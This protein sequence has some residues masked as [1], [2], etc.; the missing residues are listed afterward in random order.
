M[1]ILSS[2]LRDHSSQ[3]HYG[4]AT[5]AWKP[6]EAGVPKES[7]HGPHLCLLYTAGVPRLAPSLFIVST[8]SNSLALVIRI[9]TQRLHIAIHSSSLHPC[10]NK[11]A[12]ISSEIHRMISLPLYLKSR[13]EEVAVNLL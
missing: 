13:K 5:S 12:A 7:V 8:Q 10:R 11:V 3:V 4:E 1:K 9:V 2:Y 6:I